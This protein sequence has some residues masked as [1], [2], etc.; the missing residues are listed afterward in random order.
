MK[1]GKDAIFVLRM[2]P[3]D[4]RFH[5]RLYFFGAI[6]KY[7]V[8][9]FVSPE[10]VR[11]QIPIPNH[12]VGGA[13]GELKPLFAFAQSLFRL[14]AFDPFLCF[15][16]RAADRLSQTRRFLFQDVIGCP[17]SEALNRQLFPD[18]AGH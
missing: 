15:L 11:L 17:G 12:I 3:T 16:Q 14:L 10:I 1:A 4:P 9:T 2:K 5:A 7:F 8:E 6:A 13:S 18:G